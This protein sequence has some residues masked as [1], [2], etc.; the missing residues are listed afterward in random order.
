[1]TRL[2]GK[3]RKGAGILPRP[4]MKVV[5]AAFGAGLCWG[6]ALVDVG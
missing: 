6:T 2:S 1:M 4:G 5:I 3:S